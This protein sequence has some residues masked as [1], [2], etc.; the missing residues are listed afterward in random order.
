MLPS[1][2]PLVAF[3]LTLPHSSVNNQ[4]NA[5]ITPPHLNIEAD[6]HL[7]IVLR[8]C[9][10]LLAPP[11]EP[12]HPG[13]DS[14]RT[15]DV[16]SSLLLPTTTTTTNSSTSTSV[17][18]HKPLTRINLGQHTSSLPLS[19]G[20]DVKD[21]KFQALR[22]AAAKMELD[23]PLKTKLEILDDMEK[24]GK[25]VMERWMGEQEGM[26]VGEVVNADLSD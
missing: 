4:H 11:A 23:L 20:Q 24:H 12:T 21:S 26:F 1:F 7:S 8:I 13:H 6:Q 10:D 25:G 22:D 9:E 15:G 16:A 3:I 18:T 2:G 17:T 14:T 5:M 19:L